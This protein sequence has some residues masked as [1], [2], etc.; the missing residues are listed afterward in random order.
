MERHIVAGVILIAFF[1]LIFVALDYSK[2]LAKLDTEST[3]GFEDAMTA[4][5]CNCLPGY[6]PSNM[7][8]SFV[9]KVNKKLIDGKLYSRP[10]IG[11][12]QGKQLYM[13]IYYMP[14]QIRHYIIPRD[15]TCGLNISAKVP[16][17]FSKDSIRFRYDKYL[18]ADDGG[19]PKV[20][21][22]MYH[23][24][25]HF[26]TNQPVSAYLTDCSQIQTTDTE[27]VRTQTKTGYFCQNLQNPEQT[28][29]C[30]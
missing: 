12:V 9:N 6:V 16:T 15:N 26:K 24:F 17:S 20:S 18:W 13:I 21:E 3:E 14:S 11:L 22:D 1:V 29:K 2:N 28:A 25:Q 19:F 8:N 10:Y 7:K 4:A 5:T 30:Y 27:T 23:D